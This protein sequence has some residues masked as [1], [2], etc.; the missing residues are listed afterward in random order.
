MFTLVV[1]DISDDKNRT[2][3][4][5]ALENFG[6]NRI[7][8]SAFTGELNP[9]DR[10]V[11]LQDIRKYATGEKDSIYVIPLCERCMRVCAIIATKNISLIDDSKVKVV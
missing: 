11:L 9:H 10:H 1:Y 5:K 2:H 8:Y 7:Q 3:L 6:L 4:S